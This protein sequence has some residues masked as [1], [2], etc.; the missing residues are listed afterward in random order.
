[1]RN[2]EFKNR[3]KITGIILI[4]LSLAIN[5]FILTQLFSQDKYLEPSTTVLIVVFEVFV[6]FLGLI[7]YFEISWVIKKIKSYFKSLGEKDCWS[8]LIIQAVLLAL[9]LLVKKEILLYQF[10]GDEPS[11]LL[12]NFSS[13]RTILGNHRTFG[14]PLILKLY[15]LVFENYQFWPHFQ[16]LFYFFSIFFLYWSFLRFGLNRILSLVVVSFLLWDSSVYKIFPYIMAE[17]LAASFLH[18]SI[19]TMLLAVRRND[20]KLYLA[21]GFFTFTS[22]QLRPNLAH[23]P[24]LIPFWA[25]GISLIM[26]GFD[27]VQ[28][29]RI[30]LRFSAITIVPL[31]LFCLLRLIV[32]GQ[33]G[34]VS[35]TGGGLAGHATHYLDENNIN[36]LS[37]ESR[38]IAEEILRRKRKLSFPAN[39]SPFSERVILTESKIRTEARVFGSNLMM[40]WLV[41]IKYQTGLEPFDDPQ[42]NI[43]AWKHVDTL[44]RFY[45]KYYN[46][47]TDRL[48]MKFSEDILRIE[49]R[50]FLKWLIVGSYYGIKDH[51]RSRWVW[52]IFLIFMGVVATQY[53]LR[54]GYVLEKAW[55]DRWKREVLVITMIGVSLFA[56]GFFPIVIFNY[57]FDRLLIFSSLYSLP[58][59]ALWVLPPFWLKR[60]SVPADKKGQ[61]LDDQT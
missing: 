9:Y 45:S 40:A 59:L 6:F 38:V 7:C 1:M 58:A 35:M 54:A 53:L 50:Q 15:N 27:S 52:G 34:V 55:L 36:Y 22:Y 28:I 20:W 23:V 5:P 8:L 30:F 17:P 42:K 48:L 13:L 11:Y 56:I 29:R 46:A 60:R 21:L 61:A 3:L 24:I 4:F 26:N 16:M 14:L 37:G 51:L 44:A 39:L 43:E 47:E 10:G 32:V 33:F 25:M 18:L 49:Y 57:P 12:F 2:W 31:L 19:G 41:A